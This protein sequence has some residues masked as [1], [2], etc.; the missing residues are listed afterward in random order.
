MSDE[1][2][3]TLFAVRTPDFERPVF[4]SPERC[5]CQGYANALGAEATIVAYREVPSTD[6]KVLT[7]N[8][9]WTVMRRFNPVP[10]YYNADRRACERWRK[11]V[12]PSLE[13]VRF[14]EVGGEA[15]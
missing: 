7:P 1:P 4:L 3:R 13:M 6:G 2:L 10:L 12:G 14:D 5:P 11:E 9:I 15:A 8:S